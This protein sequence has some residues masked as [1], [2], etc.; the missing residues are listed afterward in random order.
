MAYLDLLELLPTQPDLAEC[1][2]RR[3]AIWVITYVVGGA[4]LHIAA[5]LTRSNFMWKAY[6]VYANWDTMSL[7][8]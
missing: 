5:R 2:W 4:V 8:V 6:K 1:Y 3:F 7:T